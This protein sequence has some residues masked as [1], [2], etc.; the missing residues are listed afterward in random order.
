MPK[1]QTLA[2][3]WMRHKYVL[4]DG[5]TSLTAASMAF[6]ICQFFEKINKICERFLMNFVCSSAKVTHIKVGF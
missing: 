1:N 4:K 6:E 3:P 2:G 5:I